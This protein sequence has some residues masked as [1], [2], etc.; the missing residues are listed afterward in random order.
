TYYSD[1]GNSY[2]GYNNYD[3]YSFTPYYSYSY[4]PYSSYGYYDYNSYDSCYYYNSCYSTYTTKSSY[5]DY[6]N[7]NAPQY[8]T[9]TTPSFGGLPNPTY[10]PPNNNV[11]G[12]PTPYVNPIPSP[13]PR[14]FS[15]RDPDGYEGERKTFG[16]GTQGEFQCTQGIWVLVRQIPFVITLPQSPTQNKLD[17][18]GGIRETPV[19]QN[20]PQTNPPPIIYANPPSY[21]QPVAVHCVNPTGLQGE[22]RYFGINNPQP[23]ICINGQWI[24]DP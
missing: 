9:S 8:Y 5:Y 24:L 4:T 6:T 10:T 11:Y 23:F 20:Q 22:I 17:F 3:Y 21:Q 16:I 19:Q 2:S 13:N 18:Y 14:V 1:Y 7:Y 15:C 12:G